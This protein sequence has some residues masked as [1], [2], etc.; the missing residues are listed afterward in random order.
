MRQVAASGCVSVSPAAAQVPAKP[1]HYSSPFP[2]RSRPPRSLSIFTG[3]HPSPTRLIEY[4]FVPNHATT[5][6]CVAPVRSVPTGRVHITTQRVI[7]RDYSTK[8]QDE[9][10]GLD[11]IKLSSTRGVAPDTDR[12][13]VGFYQGDTH[14]AGEE[15]DGVIIIGINRE[16]G[17]V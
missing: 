10:I 2:V 1:W 4:N 6:P 7:V 17:R 12:A 5:L 8:T 14:K 15:A 16:N 3:P 9:E 13:S 11:P